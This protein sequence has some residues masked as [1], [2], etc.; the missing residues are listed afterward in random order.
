M[1][2]AEGGDVSVISSLIKAGASVLGREEKTLR[3]PLMIAVEAGHVGA[4][5]MLLASGSNRFALDALGR[6]AL[7]IAQDRKH[8]ALVTL[9]SAEPTPDERRIAKP[10][11]GAELKASRTAKVLPESHLVFLGMV[12]ET[13]PFV[14]EEADVASATI[15]WGEGDRFAKVSVG[16]FVPGTTWKLEKATPTGHFF[17]PC[18][19][20]RAID[21]AERVLL[22][23][24]LPARQ[25]KPRAWLK[26]TP[27]AQLFEAVDGDQF[28]ITGEQLMSL[29]V[30]SVTPM[31]VTLIN[32]ATKT[33]WTLKPG[34]MR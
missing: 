11:T 27:D 19:T 34:G 10:L 5:Q 21:S 8:S 13:L 32:D 17:Q 23:K 4:A 6:C 29:R 31:T 9:L 2:A 7:D 16:E 18:A 15:R 22:V 33:S 14:V 20:L 12:E 30:Q 26:F 24:G 25:G 1:A 3:T 28:S